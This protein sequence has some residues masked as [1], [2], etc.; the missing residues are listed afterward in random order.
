VNT[1]ENKK[2]NDLTVMMRILISK[3]VKK[4]TSLAKIENITNQ[5]DTLYKQAQIAIETK[6]LTIIHFHRTYIK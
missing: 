6:A 4:T 5:L 2:K 1:L 3:L